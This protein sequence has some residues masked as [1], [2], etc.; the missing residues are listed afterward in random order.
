MPELPEVETIVRYL[1]SRLRGKRILGLEVTAVKVLRGAGSVGEVR[2]KIINQ[3]I[4]DVERLGKNIILSLENKNYLLFHLMMTGQLLW[5]P[6]GE[7]KHDR[8]VLKLSGNN[9]LV[10]NDLRLFGKCQLVAAEKLLLGPDA[11]VVKF[12]EFKKLLAGKKD[13]IKSLLMNQKILAGIGN[14]YADEILW[15]AGIKPTR[16]AVSLNTFEL[17]R[18]YTAMG[19]VLRAAIR[20]GGTS[21]RDYLKPDGSK[22]EYYELRKAYQREGEKCARDGA[23][24][25]IIKIGGRSSHFC[26]KHQK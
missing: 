25:Q 15:Y 26:P 20:K 7:R 4:L 22:G 16:K 13:A 17:K 2:K 1:R 23:I 14:I 3:K 21:S 9:R 10:F 19:K 12:A 18:L 8:L 6:A 11:L 5:N 24:I